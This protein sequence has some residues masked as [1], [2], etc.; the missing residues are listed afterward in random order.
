[1]YIK[2]QRKARI[3]IF[4]LNLGDMKFWRIIV[5][6]DAG[7]ASMEDGCSSA[8]GQLIMLAGEGDKC[9]VLAWQSNKIKR[10]VKSTLAA[11]MLSLSDALDY[12]IYV[13]HII[14]ELTVLK[15]GELLIRAYVDNQS[16][17]GTLYS[18]KTV[19][20]KRLRIDIGAFK[21]LM[22][23]NEVTSVQWIPG[24]KM[25]ANALTKRGTASFYLLELLQSGNLN[26]HR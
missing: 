22:Q 15:E 25:S 7:H 1:M 24:K 8:G 9:C 18:T 13:R 11:D 16:V 4:F 2:D 23:R 6:S 10:V 20:D 21:Q 5:E 12:A 14:S 26:L 17:V 19:D 3:H